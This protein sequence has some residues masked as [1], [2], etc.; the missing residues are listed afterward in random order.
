MSCA[1]PSAPIVIQNPSGQAIVPASA[2][3]PAPAPAP[4]PQIKMIHVVYGM[5]GGIVA[6]AIGYAML[7]GARRPAACPDPRRSR[8]QQDRAWSD[9]E[10]LQRGPQGRGNPS[11]PEYVDTNIDRKLLELAPRERAQ[12]GDVAVERS[13]GS[14]PRFEV[15]YFDMAH[16]LHHKKHVSRQTAAYWILEVNRPGHGPGW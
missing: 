13:P 5:L 15:A 14:P 4:E 3:T 1:V 7:E 16:G 9:Q 11:R 6:G 8:E 12:F 2:E 10:W